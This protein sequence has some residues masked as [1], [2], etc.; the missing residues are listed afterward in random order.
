MSAALRTT[1]AVIDIGTNSVKL[2]V[3]EVEAGL[4]RPLY[5]GSHQTR[6][7][8]GFYQTHVLQPR[9]IDETVKSV[10]EFATQAGGWNP[11]QIRVIATS[12]ARDAVNKDQLVQ[13]IEAASGLTV[14]IISGEQEADWAYRGAIS[15]PSLT[16]EDLLVMD[17][18]G[19]STEFILG[20]GRQRLY[21]RSFPIG[22]VRLL[23][24][25]KISDPPSAQNLADCEEQVRSVLEKDVRSEI[26]PELKRWGGKVQL[27]ATG[28]ASTILA[29]MEL[30]LSTFDRDQIEGAELSHEQIRRE[31]T[32]LWTLPLEARKKIIG[33]PPNRADV[34]L[35]GIVIFDQVLEL[36]GLPTL[37]VS[38]RGIRFAALMD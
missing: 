8:E 2:L 21:A 35:P 27:V 16:Q 1:K 29:R 34:I 17:V 19:G 30:K 26:I 18:G 20:H 10:A 36:F 28:G 5:E 23:E 38:T 33:L 12:A 15:G 7:G 11:E 37:R 9:A 22:S 4:V 3:A 31:R 24:R 32:R 14:E 6:L 13:G 25:L